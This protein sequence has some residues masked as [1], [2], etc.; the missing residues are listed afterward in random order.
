MNRQINLFIAMLVS[1]LLLI[2]CEK[3]KA[4]EGI[5]QWL[6]T[7]IDELIECRGIRK[8]CHLG[9][10]GTGTC[11]H[12]SRCTLEP[13]GVRVYRIQYHDPEKTATNPFSEGFSKGRGS[14]ELYFENGALYCHRV[15]VWD[16]CQTVLEK[17]G[18]ELIYNSDIWKEL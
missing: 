2:S 11:V 13:S 16:N 4:P 5:P 15:E 10:Q 1:S 3:E 8:C 14:I 9:E 12:V 6:K 17:N 7:R 18:E